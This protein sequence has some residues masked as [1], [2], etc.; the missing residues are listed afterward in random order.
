MASRSRSHARHART[1]PQHVGAPD[2]PSSASSPP[3]VSPHHTG[4]PRR[5][6]DVLVAELPRSH[7]K[8]RRDLI[9]PINAFCDYHR[10]PVSDLIR[11][12]TVSLIDRIDAGEV[13][14]VADAGE[15]S[16]ELRVDGMPKERAGRPRL[17]R[18]DDGH[19]DDGDDHHSQ[20]QDDRDSDPADDNG[21]GASASAAHTF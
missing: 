7:V 5:H 18:R 10:M 20:D 11:V 16:G 15:V 17:A 2:S 14:Y 12:A 21:D 6:A 13:V 9:D 3:P 1:S 8:I 19:D 4:R